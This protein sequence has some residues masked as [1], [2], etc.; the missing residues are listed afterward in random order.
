MGRVH[1]GGPG[2]GADLVVAPDDRIDWTVFD[3]VTVPAGRGPRSLV[4][5]SVAGDLSLPTVG[6]TDGC[7]GLTAHPDTLPAGDAA[8]L[9]L[10]AFP[11]LAACRSV[12]V[13]VSPLRQPFDCASLLQFPGLRRVSVSGAATHLAALA[14]LRDLQ[15]LRLLYCPDG[16]DLPPLVTWPHLTTV[17]A[18][19]LDETT[20]RRLRGEL[21]AL[22]GE[23]RG[24][25]TATALGW[26]DAARE[27]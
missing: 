14:G 24:V 17:L 18:A 19:N 6:V 12:D 21:R 23:R 10:P 8:P 15:S 9:A 1:L 27:F 25:P 2:S 13:Y 5:L 26:F 22:K 11:G 3:P 7:P 16:A 20:G 4:D